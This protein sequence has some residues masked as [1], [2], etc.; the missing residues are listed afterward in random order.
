V[1]FRAISESE[2]YRSLW[3]SK[4]SSS[5]VTRWVTRAIPEPGRFPPSAEFWLAQLMGLAPTRSCPSARAGA[6]GRF[7]AADRSLLQ[8]I[9]ERFDQQIAADPARSLGA[10][11]SAPGL[12]QL[13]GAEPS[14]PRFSISAEG[15]PLS[16]NEHFIRSRSFSGW[17]HTLLVSRRAASPRFPRVT[18]FGG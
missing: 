8:P 3:K 9:P 6:S 1:I 16:A 14:F 12:V 7:E 4:P 2:R 13:F 10:E 11:Q 17:T 18:P 5:T 15:P